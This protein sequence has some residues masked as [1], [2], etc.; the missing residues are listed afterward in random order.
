M[1]SQMIALQPFLAVFFIKQTFIRIISRA[2]STKYSPHRMP[3]NEPFAHF[4]I[5][6]IIIMF[7]FAL[8]VHEEWKRNK[9][10]REPTA[11]S[12]GEYRRTAGWQHINVRN[13]EESHMGLWLGNWQNFSRF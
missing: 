7:I 12:S 11:E 2:I 4:Q 5:A 13:N 9:R 3:R 1:A 8:K 6:I 10:E